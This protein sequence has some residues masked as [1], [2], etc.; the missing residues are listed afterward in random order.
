MDKRFKKYLKEQG[1]KTPDSKILDDYNKTMTETVIPNII[2]NIKRR[3]WYAMELR[4]P[5]S[6]R[7][8]PEEENN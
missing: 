2:E 3:E 7:S 6:A 4:F 8:G 5:S 1:V